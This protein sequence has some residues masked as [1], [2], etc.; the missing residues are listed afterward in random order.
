MEVLRADFGLQPDNVDTCVD[1]GCFFSWVHDIVLASIDADGTLAL[2]NNVLG[3]L[4]FSMQMHEGGRLP[5]ETELLM[6]SA[7]ADD[8]ANL[9][10]CRAADSETATLNM[11][12]I[13]SGSR[14]TW[15]GVISSADLGSASNTS[16]LFGT[17]T[18][19]HHFWPTATYYLNNTI[20]IT[21]QLL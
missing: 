11:S 20:I 6:F 15:H 8:S 21:Y 19:R 18:M 1:F 7:D 12:A 13:V 2:R 9:S 16:S 17:V 10:L 14:R 5:T 4:L 3:G